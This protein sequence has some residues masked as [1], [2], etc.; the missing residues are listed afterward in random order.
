MLLF[1][2]PRHLFAFYFVYRC[3]A[4]EWISQSPYSVMTSRRWLKSAFPKTQFLSSLYSHYTFLTGVPIQC[5]NKSLIL[6]LTWH[7]VWWW[8]LRLEFIV[9]SLTFK[10]CIYLRHSVMTTRWE[11]CFQYK[12]MMNGLSSEGDGTSCPSYRSL[13]GH[14]CVYVRACVHACVFQLMNFS[15]LSWH[16]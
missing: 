2:L 8:F 3:Q 4:L 15:R 6:L 9:V 14:V 13:N 1:S 16:L 7:C 11:D 12:L 5:S 10:E